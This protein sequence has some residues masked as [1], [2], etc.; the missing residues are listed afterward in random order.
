V[1]TV[2]A[3]GIYGLTAMLELGMRYKRGAIQIRDIAG[4]HGIPQHYLEQI[5]VILKKGELVE[6]F[7][8]AQGGYA[9]AKAPD[10]IHVQDVLTLLEGK[11]EIVPE[12]KQGG[13]LEFFW[14]GLHRQIED[15]L[16]R[17]LDDLI[18][19]K[20]RAEEALTYSI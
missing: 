12:K 20:R 18:M 16:D 1:F 10:R 11:L 6:S 4:K 19:E 8:G 17:T 2:S 5:L 3:K 7:R 15:Y 14:S 9:L 13:A